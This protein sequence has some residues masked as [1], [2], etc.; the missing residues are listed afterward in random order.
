MIVDI[1]YFIKYKLCI[2]LFIL[3]LRLLY[4]VGNNIIYIK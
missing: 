1:R 3:I 2:L 4:E